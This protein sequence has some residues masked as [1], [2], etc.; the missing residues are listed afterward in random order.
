MDP[1]QIQALR[2]RLAQVALQHRG[3]VTSSLPGT[4]NGGEACA[5]SVQIMLHA[6]F[7]HDFAGGTGDIK[8]VPD[9][10]KGLIA[11]HWQIIDDQTKAQPGDVAVQNGRHDGGPPGSSNPYEN[12]IGIVVRDPDNGVL[13]IMNNSS[14]HGTFSNLDTSMCFA[15]YYTGAQDGPPRFYRFNG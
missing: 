13:A 15:G 7:G 8:W 14:S 11:A 4:T 3:M 6:T 2:Q 9:L 5:M 12:H 10:T 1:Q